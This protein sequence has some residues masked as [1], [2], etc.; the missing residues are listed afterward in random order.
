MER[1]EAF[2]KKMVTELA[3]ANEPIVSH[4]TK[5]LS[6]DLNTFRKLVPVLLEKGVDNVNLSMFN[7]ETRK[8]LLNAL[9]EE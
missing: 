9:G 4:S 5:R 1:D 6:E 3:D 7:D 2:V 8:K